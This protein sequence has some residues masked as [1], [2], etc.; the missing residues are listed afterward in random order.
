MLPHT[1]S[2]VNFLW[3]KLLKRQIFDDRPLFKPGA[4]CLV[5]RH[6]ELPQNKTFSAIKIFFLRTNSTQCIVYIY[7][8][9]PEIKLLFFFF[10]NSQYVL[11]DPY[12]FISSYRLSDAF[13]PFSVSVSLHSE[14]TDLISCRWIK[15]QLKGVLDMIL[16]CIRR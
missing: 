12:N 14:S 11:N 16:N 5:H 8:K 15:K 4:L 3:F 13:S 1:H 6:F 9:N 7:G 2:S 10:L